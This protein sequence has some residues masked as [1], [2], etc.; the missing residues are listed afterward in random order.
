MAFGLRNAAQTFQRFMD[1]ILRDLDFC[2]AYLD[3]ILVFSRSF[4]EHEQHIRKLFLQLQP[5]GILINPGKCVFR[6]PE[7]T[8]LRYRI[9]IEGSRPLDERVSHLQACPPPKT[10]RQLR[11]FLGM[12]NFYRRFLPQAVATQAPLHDILSG[13]KVK[14]WHPISW[15][16]GLCKSFEE[17]KAGLSL[18]TLLA[19]PDSSAQLA[20]VTDLP[21]SSR[22]DVNMLHSPVANFT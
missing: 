3:D 19:Q 2:F 8:F 9:S 12:L 5:Y 14:S 18:A 21:L 6:V 13:P 11:K 22:S 10:V 4:E 1:D 17:C 16:P 20:H 7:L 15:T